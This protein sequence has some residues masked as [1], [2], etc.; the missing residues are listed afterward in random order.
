MLFKFF[1]HF[2]LIFPL[3]LGQV[4]RFNLIYT[5]FIHYIFLTALRL[6]GNHT[7]CQRGRSSFSKYSALSPIETRIKVCDSVHFIHKGHFV[8]EI[9]LEKICEMIS[10]VKRFEYCEA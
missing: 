3:F 8:H 6:H 2:G 5:V 9:S 1:A 10:F 4:I 7:C